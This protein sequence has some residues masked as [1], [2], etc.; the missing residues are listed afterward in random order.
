MMQRRCTRIVLSCIVLLGACVW[1]RIALAQEVVPAWLPT[2]TGDTWVYQN[3]SR[4]GA[5]YGGI[6]HPR[7]VR[8][9][10]EET[11]TGSVVLAEGTLVRTETKARDPIPN[12]VLRS[13][14]RGMDFVESYYLIRHNCRFDLDPQADELDLNQF[15]HPELRPSFRDNL[16]RGNV[17]PDICFPLA[18]GKTWGQVPET[19]LA[20]DNVWTV[21]DVNPADP[22]S[23][24]KG[25]TFHLQTYEGAG[26][27]IDRWYEQGVGVVREVVFHNGTYFEDR[28][29]L[30]R[31]EATSRH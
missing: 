8:W 27:T 26:T 28:R 29:Q 17:P 31:F 2:D 4:D 11:I 18:V 1:C 16:A 22:A 7:V 30:L 25:K 21:I 9:K 15:P 13:F 24:D 20:R 12:H 19:A 5:S 3:E 6:A 23:P 14:R 10:T